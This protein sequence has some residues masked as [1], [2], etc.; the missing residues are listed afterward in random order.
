MD[1]KS[2]EF[3][4]RLCKDNNV[5]IAAESLFISQQGLSRMI[6]RM[7]NELGVKLFRRS[8]RGVTP[9]VEGKLLWEHAEKILSEYQNVTDSI[10]LNNSL[11]HGTVNVVLELGCLPLLT[12][13]PFLRFIEEY[14]NV[15]LR[16]GEHRETICQSQL[17]D[18]TADVFFAVKAV[19]SK[20]FDVKPFY[21]LNFIVYVPKNHL[22]AKKSFITVEDLRDTK[23]V[24][25][26]STN[27]YTVV[28]DC[29]EAN[30]VPNIVVCSTDINIT[31]QC[32][33]SGLGVSPFILG[34][35][36][37]LPSSE[38][39]VVQPYRRPNIP[40]IHILTKKDTALSGGA[41]KFCEYFL[42]YFET[43]T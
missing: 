21:S 9:T 19:D 3:F 34:M 27:Y 25:C 22:L 17:S 31:M 5:S 26:G 18:G 28:K 42:R 38:D 36:K 12:L 2:L 43:R 23:L 7:E 32:V 1:I 37:A 11:I 14:P 4:V 33:Q 29:T 6:K 10:N 35:N 39:I 20:Q 40:Q 41:Q 24:L 8:N 13:S 16:F 15:D 30:F